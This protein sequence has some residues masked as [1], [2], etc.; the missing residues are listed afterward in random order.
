MSHMLLNKTVQRVGA[1]HLINY[2]SYLSTARS[3][4]DW[5]YVDTLEILTGFNDL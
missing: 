2:S 4:I 1:C 5:H 3:L